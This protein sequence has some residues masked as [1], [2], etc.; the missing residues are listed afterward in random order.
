MALS[1]TTALSEIR[2]LID[3]PN[4]QFYSNAELTTW[5][6]QGCEN[7][8]QRTRTLRRLETV[9]V[10]AQTQ[11]YT[12]PPDFYAVYRIEFVPTSTGQVF[13]YPLDFAGY[14]EMDQ[15]WGVYQTFPAAW[16]QIFTLWG[17]P[18]NL[19][20]RLFPVPD[21]GGLLNV[22]GYREPVAVVN[23]TDLVDVLQGYEEAIIEYATYKA[24][25]KDNDTTWQEAKAN[26][27][28]ILTDCV[29]NTGWFTDM[30]NQFTSGQSQWPP[31][32]LAGSDFSG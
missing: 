5:I 17:N 20:I 25:R 3:E 30:P 31:W 1:L 27:E 15:S 24:K 10:V 19:Q 22:F 8:A 14:H 11:N 6:N 13:I 21:Q 12:A 16:P 2:S 4:P 29:D 7:F 23:G 32:A 18:P 9:P 28:A 26:Y